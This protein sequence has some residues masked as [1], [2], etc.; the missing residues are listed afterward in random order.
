MLVCASD[1]TTAYPTDAY[2]ISAG[3][4]SFKNYSF[5][6]KGHMTDIAKLSCKF[7]ATTVLSPELDLKCKV[8]DILQ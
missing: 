6:Q 7:G 1:G 3:K 5:Y 8:F 2:T 4:L